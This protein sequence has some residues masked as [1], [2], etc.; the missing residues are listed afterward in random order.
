VVGQPRQ[1]PDQSRLRHPQN[2]RA[3][4]YRLRTDHRHQRNAPF[5]GARHSD[6]RRKEALHLAVDFCWSHLNLNRIQLIVFK[7]N[8]RA[9]RAYQAAGFKKE[10]VLR[11]A[12]FIGGEWVD[13]V[14][15][16]IL[17]PTP[18]RQRKALPSQAAQLQLSVA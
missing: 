14:P 2:R 5:R 6:W 15:M 18:K 12:A 16:A 4:D 8:Q 7:H 10:G 9:I 1:G 13:L 11:K 17:R 3:A